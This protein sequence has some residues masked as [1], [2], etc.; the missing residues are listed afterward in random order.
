MREK[1]LW[2]RGF[3]RPLTIVFL[4]LVPFAA[5][6]LVRAT[7][8]PS[9]GWAL[10]CAALATCGG[11]ALWFVASPRDSARMPTPWLVYAA[12]VVPAV[13]AMGALY[14]RHFGGA[15]VLASSGIPDAGNHVME[16]HLFVTSSPGTYLGFVSL[17]AVVEWLKRFARCDDFQA[18]M[19]ATYLPIAIYASVGVAAAA[20]VVERFA[21]NSRLRNIGIVSALVWSVALLP[22]TL[23]QLHYHHAQGF[24][25]PIFGL[26]PLVGLWL[27]DG[28]LRTPAARLAAYVLLLSLYR[29]TYGLNLPDLLLGSALLRGLDARVARSWTSRSLLALVAVASVAAGLRGIQILRTEFHHPGPFDAYD[30]KLVLAGQWLLICSL[31]ALCFSPLAKDLLASSGIKRWVRLPILFALL[32]ALFMTIVEKPPQGPDYYYLKSNLHPLLLLLASSVV[33]VAAL[34]S[35]AA[36]AWGSSVPRAALVRAGVGIAM[37]ACSLGLIGFGFG[38]YWPSFRERAFGSPPFALLKPLS[39]RYASRRISRVLAERHAKFGGYLTSYY[40]IFNFMNAS[41]D[42][43]N[44]GISFYLGA[45][46][47]ERPGYCVFWEGGPPESRIEPIFRHAS[48]CERLALDPRRTCVGYHPAWNPDGNRTLCW[49]C[50]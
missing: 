24:F 4:I 28:L 26:L 5:S 29:Y 9:M 14:N 50:P 13:L 11:L 12:M 7:T 23:P 39:D 41:F 1:Y 27:S 20:T 37:L 36:S 10:L 32:N 34:T 45:P 30:L 21:T 25:P 18:F 31:A 22:V 44:G 40:P 48:T 43:W 49:I 33:V 46:P 3:P 38:R 17:Y 42:Y 19:V 47:A 8:G 15:P 6:G 2:R 35:G 16:Q